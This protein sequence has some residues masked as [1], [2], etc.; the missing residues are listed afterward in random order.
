MTI[1]RIVIITMLALA[2]P[3]ANA[4]DSIAVP[5]S[6]LT[7]NQPPEVTG[8]GTTASAAVNSAPQLASWWNEWGIATSVTRSLRERD[9]EIRRLLD[10]TGQPGVL[11]YTQVERIDAEV[12]VYYLVGDSVDVVGAGT[13]ADDVY[14]SYIQK[15]RLRA[16]RDGAKVDVDHSNFLW[17][18]KAGGQTVQVTSTPA[19]FVVYPAAQRL[20]DAKLRDALNAAADA[21]ALGMAVDYLEQTTKDVA[22]KKKIAALKASQAETNQRAAKIESDL[23][24]ALERARKA[25][26][27]ALQL[28]TMAAIFNV[29]TQVASAS[30][31]LGADAPASIG[32]A[33]TPQELKAAVGSM[34]ADSIQRRDTLQ[35]RFRS[36]IDAKSQQRTQYLQILTDGKYPTDGVPQ[37]RP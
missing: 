35:V 15:D 25:Q 26:S 37:V 2:A 14:F 19:M 8:R 5:R 4:Q 27:V 9:S 29:A 21:K 31:Y 24:Q 33:K 6:R 34:L 11:V 3:A 7:Q 18:T 12:P 23:Q 32:D 22:L 36:A 28:D 16:A 1:C 17:F 10:S 13:T 20:G 30:S